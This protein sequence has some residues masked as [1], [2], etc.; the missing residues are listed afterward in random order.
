MYMQDGMK[1]LD[2]FAFFFFSSFRAVGFREDNIQRKQECRQ[3]HCLAQQADFYYQSTLSALDWWTDAGVF[4]PKSP[5]YLYNNTC[6]TCKHSGLISQWRRDKH[7]IY[8]LFWSTYRLDITRHSAFLSCISC[9]ENIPLCLW[10]LSTFPAMCDCLSSPWRAAPVSRHISVYN[11]FPL[12]CHILGFFSCFFPP[13]VLHVRQ[14]N[15]LESLSY[16]CLMEITLEEMRETKQNC[17]QLAFSQ[18]LENV[19][20]VGGIQIHI[21]NEMC[22]SP[23]PPAEGIT[24]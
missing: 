4:S 7:C 18:K 19:E 14:P 17:L 24:L 13:R 16:L 12:L 20:T 11:R 1:K 5:V 3:C 6:I 22:N 9:F 15:C 23:W 10:F 21:L 2:C 8:M